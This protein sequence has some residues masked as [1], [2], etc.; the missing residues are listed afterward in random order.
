M[1]P[2]PKLV[3]LCLACGLVQ[4]VIAH[5]APA[6]IMPKEFVG[7]WCMTMESAAAGYA[8][9]ERL[10]TEI[11]K[12]CPK[13]TFDAG[14]D[15]SLVIHEDGRDVPTDHCRLLSFVRSVKRADK[16][17]G[18]YIGRWDCLNHDPQAKPNSRY[19]DTEW[20]SIQRDGVLYV[21]W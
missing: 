17:R 20:L 3:L 2:V 1:L 10:D 11:E 14:G 8:T 21:K 6:P 19:I 15:P 4:P 13:D 9:Y 16:K 18:D 7:S 12:K 5:A